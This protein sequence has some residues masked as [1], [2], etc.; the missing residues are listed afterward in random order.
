[1]L[2]LDD[3]H[4]AG[5]RT[6]LLLRHVLDRT[7]S[8]PLLVLGSYRSTEFAGE[9]ALRD[10]LADLR[11]GCEVHRV[12]IA[13]LS[14]AEVAELCLVG[15]DDLPEAGA[16]LARALRRETAGNPFL[17]IELLRHLSASDASPEQIARRAHIAQV[18]S[19]GLPQSVRDS[20]RA[21]LARLPEP[22]VGVLQCAAVI[23]EDFDL[24]LL[25]EVAGLPES[26]CAQAI[27][28]AVSAG[29][30]H[31]EAGAPRLTFVSDVGRRALYDEIPPPRRSELHRRVARNL[32][33][34]QGDRVSDLA[35]HWF[36]ASR[37]AGAPARDVRTAVGYAERAARGE[38]SSCA[39]SPR[40]GR[41]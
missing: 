38:R 41:I 13:G 4:W 21:R 2:V 9:R 3:L 33:A 17:V 5:R 6:L 34:S 15:M 30:V 29:L 10:A 35:D 28:E 12:P 22:A 40:P 1:M 20:V 36:G 27:D 14:E 19:L 16:G 7:S 18:A 23:G 31:G 37:A 24:T 8:M 25:G 11:D 39:T 26:D 32:E